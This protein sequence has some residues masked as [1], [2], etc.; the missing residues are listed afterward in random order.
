MDMNNM[1]MKERI[2][3][4]FLNMCVSRYRYLRILNLSDSTYETLPWSISKLRHLRFLSLER[5]EKIKRVPDSICKLYNLQVLNLAGCIKLEI[6]PKGLTNLVSLR[7]LG[8]TTKEAVLRIKL[9]TLRTLTIT[10]CGSLKSLPLD[11][12]HFPKLETLLVDNCEYLDLTKGYDDLNSN[13][14]LK[15]IHLHFLPQLSTLPCW[16]QE[17]TNTLQSLLVVDFKNLENYA[18]NANHKLESIGPTYLTSI[19]F[20]LIK[21]KI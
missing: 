6:L 8:I 15:A 13:L 16:L 11:I 3:E 4:C 14:R 19:K 21:Q 17:S 1:E 20:S 2:Y 18:E 12:N 10:K 7:Q 9:P 5:N